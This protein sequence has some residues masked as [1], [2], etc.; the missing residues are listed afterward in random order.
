[1]W[2]LE[3]EKMLKRYIKEYK[4]FEEKEFEDY[5]YVDTDPYKAKVWIEE[6]EKVLDKDKWKL[7]EILVLIRL[8]DSYKEVELKYCLDV[9][10][11]LN[12]GTFEEA[13]AEMEKQSHSATSFR[14]V[15]S[16]IRNLSENGKDFINYIGGDF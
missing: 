10:K 4:E 14:L 16:M 11:I 15:C 9:I 7:W 6:G 2:P 8:Y 3:R 12:N 1:M 13:K 5:E